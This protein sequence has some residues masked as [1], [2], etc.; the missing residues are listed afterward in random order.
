[1]QAWKFSTVAGRWA[2]FGPY[3][4][5][6][7]VSFARYVVEDMCPAGGRVLDPFCGRGTAPFVAQAT[8]RAAVGVDV[9]PA[10]WVFAKSKTAP[11]RDENKLTLRLSDV[12]RAIRKRDKRATNEFQKWAWSP[13]VLGFLKSA[14]RVLNWREN[15]TDRTLMGFV[16][17]HV[18]AKLG[19]GLSNQM[20]KARA[21][22]PDYSVRWWR[23]Q[24]MHP[25]KLNPEDYLNQRIKW[26][27]RH[28]V[29]ESNPGAEIVL[30][31]AEEELP[32]FQNTK[33]DLLFTSPPYFGIT[34]YRQ[35]SWIR[36]WLLNEGPVLPDWKKDSKISR[37]DEYK[38][39]L[40][41]VFA[42][43][44]KLLKP[45]GVVWVR[46]D[47]REFTKWATVDALR[48]QWPTRKLYSRS[49]PL[50]CRTQTAHFGDNSPKPGEVDF[51]IPGR[52]KPAAGFIL[53]P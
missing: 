27:Y 16:L 51:L 8:G 25:P 50:K 10:A 3:Y 33:F 32:R 21:L 24:N 36:L 49:E 37:Q 47:A 6:F 7:P 5:M 13:E 28:G 43:T 17:V 40:N 31:S 53:Y 46:T 20:H 48:K 29:V 39:M 18:H 22:G 41:S 2:G 4:A 38:T 34:N 9:N 26:R 1:M 12:C 35:D 14:R 19:D 45:R 44:A 42:A 15:P 11:E 52:K 30:G 23:N